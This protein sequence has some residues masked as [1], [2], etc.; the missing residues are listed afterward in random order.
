MSSYLESA[1]LCVL[2]VS[3]SPSGTASRSRELLELALEQLARAGA[4][5]EHADLSRLPA[6][7][8]LGREPDPAVSEALARLQAARILVVATPVYRA[9]YSG[10]L[11]VF[12]DL[13]PHG[14]LAG[15]VVV[16]I[17]TGGGPA[18]QL[19]VDHG[20]RPLIAS[21]GGLSVATGVYAQP[22]QFAAGRPEPALV[23]RVARATAE[24]LDLAATAY[25]STSTLAAQP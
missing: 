16:P 8:L 14:A 2:G 5:V 1:P 25:R 6:A 20:L 19:A 3:A 22:E 10:L 24:A 12:F 7:A 17:A 13:L 9:T 11:K 4:I 23:D 18:H 15:K 21:L